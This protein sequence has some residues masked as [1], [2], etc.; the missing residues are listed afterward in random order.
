MCHISNYE[1]QLTTKRGEADR[2][3]GC[4]VWKSWSYVVTTLKWLPV[5]LH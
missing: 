5:F 4:D 1:K 3:G 2:E